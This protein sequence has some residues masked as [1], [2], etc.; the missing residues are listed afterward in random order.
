MENLELLVDNLR[1]M[2]TETEWLEFKHNYYEP[3]MI[4]EDISALANSSALAEKDCAYMIWGIHDE[5]HEIIGTEFDQ[6]TRKVKGQEMESWLRTQL[7]KNADFEFDSVLMNGKKVVVLIIRKA[8][9]QPVSFKKADYI[10]IGS[11][12]KKLSDNPAKQA[13]LWD[14]LR[15]ANFEEQIAK[16]DLRA[17]ESLRL[18]DYTIYFD[19]LGIPQP[20]TIEGIIHYMA[21]D[22]II[23]RQ[24]NG[25]FSISNMGALLFAKKLSDFPRI[26]RKAIRVVQYEDNNRLNILKENTGS[27]GYVLEFAE[28]IRYIEA[29]LPSQEVIEGAFRE[30]KT[31][32][33]IS[34]LRETIANA[35][36][37]Q[38]FSVTGAGPV[39]EI[40][41]N[42][43]EIT[44]PGHPLVDIMRIIDNPPQSRNEKLASLM[45]RLKMCEELGT[46]WDKIAI[47]CEF[48]Q[49]PAPRIDLYEGS[50]RVTLFSKMLFS[51]ISFEDK[52]W[53]CY[54][55]AC[56]K[57]VEGDQM[58]NQSLRSRFDLSDSVS[59]GIS[60]LFKSA[61]K[62]KLIKPL[63]ADTSPRY[64]KYL[65]FWG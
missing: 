54:L 11:Y 21:E 64:M 8:L 12:T 25:L 43:I 14:R 34:A 35:L 59:A 24:D 32:Y 44:N 55:H 15:S 19:I 39:V 9:Y 62:R 38:D 1:K 57:Y 28:F 7:S 45:R 56:V 61:I 22:S 30:K 40:F 50:T 31:A 2:P 42:R 41:S 17:E 46:G 6:Y 18:L 20:P 63:D 13:Q 49:L 10:R 52:L 4:G 23:I 58:T 36:I 29:L 26:S 5:T 47:S 33:P 53:A 3:D 37:H 60:R 48:A 65:P 16:N 51:N 27:K